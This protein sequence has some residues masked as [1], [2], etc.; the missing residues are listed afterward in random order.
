MS[1]KKI[2]VTGGCGYI[3]SHTIVDLL[4]HG[5]DVISADNF[6]NADPS[7]LKGI[8]QITGKEIQ[9][10]M[11]DLADRAAC[12]SMFESC[13][14]IDGIIH[15][16]AF[17][18]VGDS[19][20][21]PLSYYRNNINSQI[22]VM[23]LGLQYGVPSFVFSSSCSVYGNPDQLPVNE[24]TPFKKAESPYAFT[25]Q[26]GEQM[27]RDFAKVNNGMKFALLRY[28]NPAG[29]HESALIGENPSNIANNLVPV[30][31]ETAIGKR[32]QLVV[33]GDDYPTRDG[34]CIRDYIHV[35]DLGHAHTLA[36]SFLE[37]EGTGSQVNVFNLGI[38]QGVSVK[39]AVDAFES[40]TGNKLNYTFG[41]RRAGDVI[42]VYSDTKKS[43]EVLG[44]KPQRSIEQIMDT[45]W[46][47][48][49]VRSAN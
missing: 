38:G 33:F 49:Q 46:R 9:N 47:W 28:F 7:V 26:I 8:A 15:F 25:K 39:E 48:E 19:V 5:Y 37:T 22:N 36:M 41:P 30:I 14:Q 23:E 16:A 4:D 18:S 3:G 43:T 40:V 1:P 6:S 24:D 13:G 2:L 10:Y 44:W 21:S 12:V 29:A 32:K 17:K 45:A 31:T 20:D 35:M 11:V 27:I 34:T 42:A